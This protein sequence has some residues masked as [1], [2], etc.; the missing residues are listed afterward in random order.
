MSK[1]DLFILPDENNIPIQSEG[2]LKWVW[3]FIQPYKWIF[4]SVSLNRFIRF[5]ILALQP[6]MIGKIIDLIESGDGISNPNLVWE[7]VIIFIVTYSIVYLM[8]L[9]GI[10]ESKVIER[11]IRGMTIFSIDHVAKLPYEWHESQG[12]GSK[13]QRIMHARLALR[14]IL[15]M[16]LWHVTSLLGAFIG[17]VIFVYASDAS[18]YIGL[19]FFGFMSSFI[20]LSSFWVKQISRLYD[21]HNTRMENLVS[22]VYEFI[23]SFQI[24]KTFALRKKVISSAY[25]ARIEVSKY[26]YI[27]WACLNFAGLFWVVSIIAVSFNLVLSDALTIGAFSASIFLSMRIWGNLEE[28]TNAQ[29]EYYEH[30]SG[31][32][33]LTKTLK[34]ETEHLDVLPEIKYPK[35]W[36]ELIIENVSFSYKS[37]SKDVLRNID[38]SINKGERIAIVG[39]S[40]SGKSTIIKLLLKQSL[41]DKGRITLDDI[42][43]SNIKQTELLSNIAY[44]PQDIELFNGTIRENITMGMDEI[45]NEFY[46][47]CIDLAH[48]AEFLN[49]LPSGDQTLV[50]ERG[51]KLS[52]GQRQRLGIARAL[53]RDADI[54]IFDE[55]TS[56]LD[57]ESEKAI[58]DAIEKAFSGKTMVMIAH[59]LSTIK[60]CNRVYVFSDG[61]IAEQGTHKELVANEDGI[62]AKLWS[63]QSGGFLKDDK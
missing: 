10:I 52:G 27:K 16:F 63:M 37:E 54:M 40:G 24:L 42:N 13:L 56:A 53:M 22:K 35:S 3:F 44:V 12:A 2:L 30:K 15:T 14:S 7:W 48:V 5:V 49:C 61:E 33:L 41:P 21:I 23:T 51:V 62:F 8:L 9:I 47:Q 45:D 34:E 59:R 38:I 25:K 18:W 43:I 32:M 39:K 4:I 11:I 46:H 28:M 26:E 58:Q 36:K 55:A 29:M 31:F 1:K 17:T 6:F 19:L 57:S 60:F 50:G 20:L